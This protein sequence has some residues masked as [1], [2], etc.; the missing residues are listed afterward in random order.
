MLPT[1]PAVTARNAVMTAFH[2]ACTDVGSDARRVL[3]SMLPMVKRAMTDK[4][5]MV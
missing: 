1:R 5:A 2:D 4:K 3:S